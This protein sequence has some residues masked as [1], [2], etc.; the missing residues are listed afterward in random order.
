M[1]D[2]DNVRQGLSSDLGFSPQDRSENI[3]RIGEVAR[4]FADAGMLVI[5]AFISPFRAGRDA[6]RQRGSGRFHEIHVSAD[7]ATCEKRDPRGLYRKARRQEIADMTGITSPYEPPLNAEL[8]LDTANEGAEESAE[9]LV[10][11][12]LENFRL[13]SPKP[14]NS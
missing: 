6:V 9:K 14:G 11:Y 10:S 1:L 8:V 12:V 7:L 3:R 2:G 13:E 5:T 4:L